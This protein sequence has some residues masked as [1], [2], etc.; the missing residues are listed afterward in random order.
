MVHLFLHSSTFYQTH[1]VL[2]FTMLFN[3]PDT[4]KSAPSYGGIYI[5]TSCM[6]P[7]PA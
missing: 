2:C 7:G 5:P 1:K 3:W 6:F 4:P